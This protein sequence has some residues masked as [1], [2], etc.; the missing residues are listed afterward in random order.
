MPVRGVQSARRIHADQELVVR[1]EAARSKAYEAMS[2]FLQEED[3][4][5]AIGEQAATSFTFS[6]QC[7]GSQFC[8]QFLVGFA[9]SL[10]DFSR[11]NPGAYCWLQGGL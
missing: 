6:W 2:A 1:A 9:D 11:R 8:K 3:A 5:A 4:L 10:P 7:F